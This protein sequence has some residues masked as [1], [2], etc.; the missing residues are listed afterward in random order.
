MEGVTSLFIGGEQL[1][2]DMVFFADVFSSS[3]LHGSF[4]C[5]IILIALQDYMAHGSQGLF[6]QAG[7]NDPSQEDSPQNHFGMSNANPLQSQVTAFI[8]SAW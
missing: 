8:N 7:Y 1:L 6:T 4:T 2:S 5:V 3:C